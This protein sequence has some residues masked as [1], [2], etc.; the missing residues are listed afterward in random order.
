MRN[1]LHI[2]LFLPFARRCLLFVRLA[3]LR[4]AK[5]ELIA[6]PC[7]RALSDSNRPKGN[8][9]PRKT[10]PKTSARRRYARC[11][12]T[13]ALRTSAPILASHAVCSDAPI[14]HR[15]KVPYGKDSALFSMHAGISVISRHGALHAQRSIVCASIFRAEKNGYRA[16]TCFRCERSPNKEKCH[17]VK[18]RHFSHCM[19]AYR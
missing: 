11:W 8:P 16:H 13:T 6:A 10:S 17:M 4:S 7:S 18:I 19:P 2:F 3:P 1:K 14:L 9:Q 5:C 12:F 15:R